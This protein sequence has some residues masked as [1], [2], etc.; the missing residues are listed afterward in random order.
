MIEVKAVW[1]RLKRGESS[2]SSKSVAL[3]EQVLQIQAGDMR[4][5][6]HILRDYQPFVL[7]IAS[8]VCGRFIS[9]EH[10]DEFSIGLE[11]LN[12]ALDQ[13]NPDRSPSFLAFAEM[14]IRRRIIDY[15]RQKEREERPVLSLQDEEE[16]ISLVDEHAV[17][18][19]QL[20]QDQNAR[21]QEIY[22]LEEEL[23]QFNITFDQLVER[24][25][26]HR[27]ARQRAKEVV[28]LIIANQGWVD[29]FQR[30]RQLPLKELEEQVHISRKTLERQ[31]KYITAMLVILMGNY[32]RLQAFL[33]LSGKG[34][35]NDDSRM[36]NAKAEEV[37]HHHDH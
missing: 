12:E 6:T 16:K 25:P 24:A 31:R 26:K 10:D 9:R 36:C 3:E 7:R 29:Y 27:D 13:Y 14:V 37:D 2:S 23:Q 11:A 32:P 1:R 33:Q 22:Q 18:T 35:S 20:Q 21:S 30:T 34:G 19:Y 8:Q 28:Q 15:L 5:R 17:L 4:L